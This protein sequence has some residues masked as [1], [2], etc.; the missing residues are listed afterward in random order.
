MSQATA[1]ST[2][3]PTEPNSPVPSA[4][5]ALNTLVVAEHITVEPYDRDRFPHWSDLDGDGCDT[6][7][8]VLISESLTDGRVD[9]RCNIVSGGTWTSPFDGEVGITDPSSLDVDHLVPLA[10]AWLSGAWGWDDPAREAFANDLDNPYSLIAVTA[11]SNRSKGAKAP[12]EW[13]PPVEEY[14]CEYAT[15]W[16]SVK[17]DWALT[18]TSS[19]RNALAEMLATC[20]GRTATTATPPPTTA[21]TTT[22]AAQ[23]GGCAPGQVNVNTAEADE[24]ETVNGVGPVLAER[25]VELQPSY[26]T[27]DDL[28]RVDG[29]GP[30]TVDDIKAE[31]IACAA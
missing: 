26:R 31:G 24:L 22:P 9:R 18:V 17:A 7:Q 23:P 19:E 1:P 5:A 6:R 13:K 11:S 29:I 25:I 2:A 10:N 8:E 27:L 15:G 4:T 12:D 3:A 14:W 20:D 30:A 21:P 16:V 28:A